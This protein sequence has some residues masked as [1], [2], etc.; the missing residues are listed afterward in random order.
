MLEKIPMFLNV[1]EDKIFEMH[2]TSDAEKSWVRGFIQG[3]SR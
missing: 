1:G 2:L 3:S